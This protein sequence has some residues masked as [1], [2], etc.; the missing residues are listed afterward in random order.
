MQNNTGKEQL[1]MRQ[2]PTQEDVGWNK[3]C[4]YLLTE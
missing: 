3:H 2:Q 4:N 1:G